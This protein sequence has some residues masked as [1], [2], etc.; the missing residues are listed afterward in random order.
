MR[1]ED[2]HDEKTWRRLHS[3]YL[4]PDCMV[5]RN[6]TPQSVSLSYLLTLLIRIPTNE[7]IIVIS[8]SRLMNEFHYNP[9]TSPDNPTSIEILPTTVEIFFHPYSFTRFF[10]FM[11]RVGPLKRTLSFIV[12]NFKLRIHGAPS[13]LNNSYIPNTPFSSSPAISLYTC[14]WVH[15]VAIHYDHHICISYLTYK[16]GSSCTGRYKQA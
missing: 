16:Y 11:S 14:F 3:E 7:H 12:L 4:Q 1:D 8:R 9:S 15:Y 6:H 5:P 13:E 10:R 2:D